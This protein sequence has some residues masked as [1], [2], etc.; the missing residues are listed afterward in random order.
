MLSIIFKWKVSLV[1]CLIHWSLNNY[2]R[3]KIAAV[4][5]GKHIFYGT[6]TTLQQKRSF[7]FFFFALSAFFFPTKILT[8]FISHWKFL[9]TIRKNY[10]SRSEKKKPLNKLGKKKLEQKS[11]K[12]NVYNWNKAF[13][14]YAYFIALQKLLQLFDH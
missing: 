6:D 4:H 9:A 14:I 1:F 2:Y 10:V 8:S 11:W 3:S 5:K 13:V 7:F 12:K